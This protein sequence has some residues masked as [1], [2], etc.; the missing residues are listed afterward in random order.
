ML[1]EAS[2][3][4]TKAGAAP[5]NTIVKENSQRIAKRIVYAF[6]WGGGW[7]PLRPSLRSTASLPHP[8]AP[9]PL[10]SHTNT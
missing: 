6:D 9:L 2:V 4:Q 8:R 10:R 1:T 7:H 5:W 3:K